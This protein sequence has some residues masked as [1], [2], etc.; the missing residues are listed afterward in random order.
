MVPRL[1]GE[2]RGG[3]DVGSLGTELALSRLQQL[4]ST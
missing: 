4:C 3:V 2:Y 1:L